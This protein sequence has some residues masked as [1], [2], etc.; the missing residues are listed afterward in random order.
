MLNMMKKSNKK[1]KKKERKKSK[2]EEKEE[3]RRNRHP[4]CLV[5]CAADGWC[6]GLILVSI[7]RLKLGQQQPLSLPK[8]QEPH[9]AQQG[10][11]LSP[12]ESF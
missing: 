4:W 7:Y 2:K 5:F 10:V 3:G 12:K 11:F 9:L 8:N 6:L 1:G